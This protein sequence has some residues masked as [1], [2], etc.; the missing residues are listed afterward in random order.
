[1]AEHGDVASVDLHGLSR[2]AAEYELAQFVYTEHYRGTTIIAIIHGHGTG[3]LK[4]MVEAWIKQHPDLIAYARPSLTSRG[5]GTI[6][7]ILKD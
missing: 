2:L 3:T 4:T 6:F 1:M 7:A 5:S